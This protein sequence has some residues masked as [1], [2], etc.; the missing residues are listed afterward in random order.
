M[1]HSYSCS[2][3]QRKISLGELWRSSTRGRFLRSGLSASSGKSA[4][5]NA[6]STSKK[7]LCRYYTKMMKKT[8]GIQSIKAGGRYGERTWLR[9][10]WQLFSSLS[11]QT[12]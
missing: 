8:H 5:R 3:Q 2:G 10:D 12:M 1:Q 7:M 11:A 4:D 9:R 6:P